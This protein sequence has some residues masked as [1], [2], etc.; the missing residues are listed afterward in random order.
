MLAETICL[1]EFFGLVTF[2]EFVDIDQ[3]HN[4]GFPITRGIRNLFAT[5]A[6][7]IV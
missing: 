1:K 5:I 3:M 7:G 6:A 2:T 4:P